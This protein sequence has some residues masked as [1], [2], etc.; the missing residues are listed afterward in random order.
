MNSTKS[1]IKNKLLNSVS[2]TMSMMDDLIRLC[3]RSEKDS[4]L[5]TTALNCDE[6]S[7]F[8]PSARAITLPAPKKRPLNMTNLASSSRTFKKPKYCQEKSYA[9]IRVCTDWK[10]GGC[11]SNWRQKD[12]EIVG[13]YESNPAAEAAKS[14]LIEKHECR[15]RGCGGDDEVWDSWDDEIIDLVV[16]EASLVFLD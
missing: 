1:D 6:L 9:L 13:V 4:L 5:T 3:N 15:D 2:N 14:D 11:P 16:Q 8:M 12:I 7:M 10:G